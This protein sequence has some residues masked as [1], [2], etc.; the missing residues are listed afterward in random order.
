L[1]YLHKILPFFLSPLGLILIFL[2]A[3]FFFKRR[4][5]VF[6]AFIVL[7]VSS[8][9]IVGN[10]LMQK[11]EHPYKPTSIY[12]IIKGDAIVVLGGVLKKIEIENKISF[13]FIEAD[14]FF[15]SV[16]LINQSKANKLIFMASQLPWTD[17]W[18]P[19]VIFLKIKLFQ[20]VC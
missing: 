17:N 14:R 10:Y 2:M 9:P 4:I 7:I 20:W 1:I 11:L 15:S 8:N 5:F 13:E 16:E 6:L 12:S 18:K 3:S 19:E